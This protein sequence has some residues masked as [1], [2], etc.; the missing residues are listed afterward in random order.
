MKGLIRHIFIWWELRTARRKLYRALPVLR[1]F[2]RQEAEYRK[3][4]RAGSA[5]IMKAKRDALHAALAG[6]V[7]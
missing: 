5:R 4:H 2:S 7:R 1:E 3:A 6:K